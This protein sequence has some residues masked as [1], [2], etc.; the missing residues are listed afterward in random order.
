MVAVAP[1]TA[2]LSGWEATETRTEF[3]INWTVL[4]NEGDYIDLVSAGYADIGGEL[5]HFYL[6]DEIGSG[7]ETLGV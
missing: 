7:M 3:A 2:T 4:A 6:S 1:A 5:S